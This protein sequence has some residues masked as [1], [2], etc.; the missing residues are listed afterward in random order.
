VE[1]TE[2][3]HFQSDMTP[4]AGMNG[5]SGEVHDDAIRARELR[6]STR[7]ESSD[8]PRSWAILRGLLRKTSSAMPILHGGPNLVNVCSQL[9]VDG[10][11]RHSRLAWS[12]DY[13]K[14][15]TWADWH[16]SDTFGCPEFVQ[17][18]ANDKG[19]RDKYLY[20]V[21]QA[22]NDAYEYPPDMVMARV[23]KDM[24]YIDCHRRPM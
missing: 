14:T 1:R 5:R 21:S 22:N 11:Y 17:F 4:K 18:G 15:W 23:L 16:F 19:A 13:E 3:Y 2:I 24:S 9:Q 10:D 12:R 7:T 6:P 20:V 8:S